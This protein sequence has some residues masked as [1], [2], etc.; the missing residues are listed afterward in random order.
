MLVVHEEAPGDSHV[1]LADLLL[2]QFL[3]QFMLDQGMPD[4][5]RS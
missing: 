3:G 5:F 1:Y 4:L 2:N